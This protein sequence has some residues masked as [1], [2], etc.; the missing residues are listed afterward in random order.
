MFRFN[1]E[2][3]L[4]HRLAYEFIRGP[5]PDGLQLDHLCRVRRCVNPAHLEPVSQRENL[6][7]GE[8]WAGKN[9]RKTTCNKGHALSVIPNNLGKR[10]CLT[11]RK[12]V[13]DLS[14]IRKRE[15]KKQE[16]AQ[17]VPPKF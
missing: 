6:I 15:R 2:K 8:G 4:A 11:C 17:H 1:G 10:G 7:R 12:A 9:A 5:I 13:S 14:D 3:Q 16:R